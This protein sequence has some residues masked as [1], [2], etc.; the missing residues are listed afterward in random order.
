MTTV[1][2]NIETQSAFDKIIG[3]LEKAISNTSSYLNNM[4]ETKQIT[5]AVKGYGFSIGKQSDGSYGIAIIHGDDR[6]ELTFK[7]VV[8]LF[9]QLKDF[10][11]QAWNEGKNK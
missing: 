4:I 1:N 10:I 5:I 3:S 7:S 11:V 9:K 8:D 6:K 2:T